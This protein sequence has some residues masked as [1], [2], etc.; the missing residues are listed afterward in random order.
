MREEDVFF[1]AA[2]VEVLVQKLS[3]ANLQN[4]LVE[5]YAVRREKLWSNQHLLIDFNA[6]KKYFGSLL[7]LLVF[8][9][10]LTLVVIAATPM[11]QPR[12]VYNE[13]WSLWIKTIYIVT[14]TVYFTICVYITVVNECYCVY[15]V[16]HCRFQTKLLTKYVKREMDNY[17]RMHFVHKY[18]SDLYQEE[19]RQILLRSIKQHRIIKT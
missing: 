4:L 6:E 9:A 18:Y 16:L 7:V 10:V 5:F 1:G 8:T 17:K 3:L 11:E 13:N 2:I 12:F 14:S 19:V 15:T